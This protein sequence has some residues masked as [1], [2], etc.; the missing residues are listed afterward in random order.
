VERKD[1]DPQLARSIELAEQ[2]VYYV[3]ALFLL[4]T[5]G[6]LFF[7]AALDFLDVAEAG[8]LEASL[9][10]L[11][12][13]LLVFILAE[14]LGTIT[15]IVREREVRAE[16]FLLIGLI[17][18]VRRILAVTASI[19]QSLGTSRF[20][21]L[22]YELGVLTVLVV[23]LAGALFFTRRTERAGEKRGE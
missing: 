16:P 15:T 17:A 8:P 19:E 10:I 3:A 9:E 1:R 7:A 4:A 13:V 11:D 20:E 18:V 23:A 22:L 6:V 2:T 5:I 21:S 12:K 14:L